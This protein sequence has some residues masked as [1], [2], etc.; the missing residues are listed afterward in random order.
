MLEDVVDFLVDIL[1]IYN[2]WY[3]I[4]IHRC[5]QGSILD[6]LLII[7][8][9]AAFAQVLKAIFHLVIIITPNLII[10][11]VWQYS[12]Y[13]EGGLI[14]VNDLHQVIFVL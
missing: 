11:Q 10:Q 14:I 1:E 7:S 4:T 5:L 3:H 9:Y 2:L 12:M 6:S 8:L 13:N